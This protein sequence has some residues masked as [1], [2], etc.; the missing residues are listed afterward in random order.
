MD[1]NLFSGNVVKVIY[2][3]DSNGGKIFKEFKDVDIGVSY[4]ISLL[5]K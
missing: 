5:G 2:I 4:D 3:D 1:I